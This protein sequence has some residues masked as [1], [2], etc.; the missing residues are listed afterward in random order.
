MAGRIVDVRSS[1]EYA[2]GHVPGAVNVPLEELP[3]RLGELADSGPVFVVCQSGRRSVQGVETLTGEG[4]EAVSVAGGTSGW[5]E[6]GHPL[7]TEEV[8]N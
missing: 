7:Q 5:A 3:D 4:M 6:A 2:G 8:R 1:E